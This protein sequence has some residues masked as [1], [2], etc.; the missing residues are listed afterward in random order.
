MH[1]FSLNFLRCVRCGSKLELD[2]FRKETEI[3]EGILECNKCALCFPIIKKIPIIWDD[4]SKYISERMMLGGKLFHSVSHDKMKKFLKLSLSTK[5]SID[6]RTALEER[7]SKI[8][9]NSQKSKFYSIIKNELRA[10]TKSKLVLEYGCSIGVMGSFLANSNQNVF[11][12]DR[13]FSA[14]SIAKQTQKD[15]L[16]YFV[17]DLMSDVFGKTKF[18]LILALNVLELV[19]PKDLLHHIS[20]QITEGTLV[21]SDPYDFDRGKNSVKKTL[22]ESA[23]RTSLEELGVAITAKTKTPSYLP[24]NLKLNPRTTLNYKVDLIIAKK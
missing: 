23:L 7:W 14:I 17:A 21:M 18:D 16:D 5:R 8:Y 12:I 13:S 1:E 20:K 24:W 10:M 6:D 4:F 11:G 3:E 19:E 22:D 9:Q 2:V 15:N